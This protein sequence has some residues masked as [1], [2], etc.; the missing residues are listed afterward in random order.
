MNKFVLL[1]RKDKRAY[2][3]VAA[4]NMNVMPQL[5]EKDFWVCWILKIL[6]SLQGVGAHLT[7]GIG[8]CATPF[9]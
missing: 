7:C 6:F 2:F 1:T 9:F 8:A 5:V 4:A 3:E